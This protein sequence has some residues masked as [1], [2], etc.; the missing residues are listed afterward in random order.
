[1]SRFLFTVWP[2]TGHI[3]PNLAIAGHLLE[4][5]HEAAFYTGDS[6]RGAVERERCR[7]FGLRRVNEELVN[8]IALS[9]EGILSAQNDPMRL[10]TLYRQWLLDTVRDQVADVQDV[11]DEWRPDAIVC[12]PTLWA[13]FLILH[14]K[15]GIPVAVFSLIPACHLS[16]R[17]SPVIGFPAPRPRN[18]WQ[19]ARTAV[20]RQAGDWF[21]R[22][23]RRAASRLR[24]SYGLTPLR[25]SVTDH[26]ATMPLYLVPSS[27]EF[28]YQRTGL[29]AS[30]QYVGPCLR[31]PGRTESAPLEGLSPERP[32]IFVS[33]GTV[34]LD[35]KL[36]RC[37]AQGLAG[38]PVEAILATGKHR[39]ID[40]LDL[41]PRP[42]ASNIHVRSWVDLNSLLPR[43]S[44]LVNVGGPSTIMAALNEGI[45]VVIVPFAWDH[46]ETG[47]RIQESGAGVHIRPHDLTPQSLR[48]A[49][50]RILSEPTY[51][52][53]AMR[54]A[55]SF[56]RMG[57]ARRAAELV[58][59]MTRRTMP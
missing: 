49:V 51:R 40:D 39:N 28:D 52:S 35:P 34:H 41:G 47:Y 15:L 25:R 54:L 44:G 42:L 53:N 23:T 5:G 8:R 29:P 31:P 57:G 45:P 50:E 32:W 55:K 26:A 14:E 38:L 4:N 12:D 33:E 56:E 10:R 37:A 11:I 18:A 3:H 7:F 2:F 30:V 58:E 27:P 22:G 24:E 36:L 16:G 1:L 17:D 19:H 21:L 20:L 59:G 46:P 6:G 13:P 9:D 43:L 48:A